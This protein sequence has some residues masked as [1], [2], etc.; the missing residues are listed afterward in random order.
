MGEGTMTRMS[1]ECKGFVKSG[2]CQKIDSGKVYEVLRLIP[3]FFDTHP[4]I[5]EMNGKGNKQ[6]SWIKEKEGDDEIEQPM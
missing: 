1:A 3:N 5:S 4:K 2:G 6:S